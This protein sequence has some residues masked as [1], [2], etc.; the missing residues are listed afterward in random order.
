[1]TPETRLIAAKLTG[2]IM[3]PVSLGILT[4]GLPHTYIPLVKREALG[5]IMWSDSS[6]N[7][8]VSVAIPI[9]YDISHL[10]PGVVF[11]HYATKVMHDWLPIPII[12]H[13]I[14]THPT[15]RYPHSSIEFV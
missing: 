2:R 15:F 3:V 11:T 13:Q 12:F 1:M 6:K 8:M 5:N 14:V 10:S 7:W 4:E 9:D